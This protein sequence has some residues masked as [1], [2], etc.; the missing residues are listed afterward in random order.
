MAY[1]HSL[2]IRNH[3][4][5]MLQELDSLRDDV[6][7]IR[8]RQG[9]TFPESAPAANPVFFRTYSRRTDAG[10]RETWDQV[11]DRTLR[12]LV[13]LGKLTHEETAILDKMQRTPT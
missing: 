13:E 5:I 3:T 6:G 9:A 4:Q 11:C 12:G 2:S 7:V 10:L 1:S 8:Q